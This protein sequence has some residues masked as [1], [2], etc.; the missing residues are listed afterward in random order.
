[1]SLTF[2]AATSD[3]A[4]KTS[5]TG[6]AA[7]AAAWSVGGWVNVTTLTSQRVLWSVNGST[8]GNA[9]LRLSGTTGN[10]QVAQTGTTSL[11]YITNDTPLSA[12]G[13]WFFVAVSVTFT[14]ATHIYVGSVATDAAERTY[15]TSTNGASVTAQSG[16]IATALGNHATNQNV[17]IQG[18]EGGFWQYYD[19]AL[20]LAEW[21]SVQRT[22]QILTSCKGSWHP[23]DD[24]ASTIID[25]SGTG[26]NLTITGATVSANPLLVRMRPWFHGS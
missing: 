20:S 16:T 1:M 7:D 11:S 22:G 6:I 18:I 10:L 5:P 21:Q 26:N 24:G 3:R 19:R 25:V 23:G 15:G 9:F 12:T 8:A 14:T 4:I 13:S 2:G 17:A